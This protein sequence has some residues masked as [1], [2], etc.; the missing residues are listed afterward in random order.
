MLA[1]LGEEPALY[2]ETI[3]HWLLIDLLTA[4]SVGDLREIMTQ[5]VL[6]AIMAHA[7]DLWRS[8]H[9]AAADTIEATAA[10]L[11]DNDKTLAKRLRRCAHKARGR[12]RIA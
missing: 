12:S 4:L 8:G 2:Q 1:N 11:R 10:A 3:Q 9:P 6:E 5:D 7:D